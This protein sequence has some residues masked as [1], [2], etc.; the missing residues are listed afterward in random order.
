MEK[1]YLQKVIQHSTECYVGK[2]DPRKLIKIA[3]VVEAGETQDAQRPLKLSKVKDIAKFVEDN[4]GILPTS[5][6]IASKGDKIKVKKCD[7]LS[8]IYYFELPT[9]DNEIADFKECIE[10]MDGQHRLYSFDYDKQIC[11]LNKTEPYELPFT[12]YINPSLDD[13]KRVFISCNEKQD[14]VDSNLLIF[15]KY[16]LGMIKK[17]EME[18]HELVEKLSKDDPLKGHII[19]SAEKI[20]NG[21]KS[22]EII[23]A[24]EKSGINKLEIKGNCLSVDDKF[25]MIRT[26]LLAWEHLVGFDFSTSTKKNAGTA[27][28]SAGLKY[29]IMLLP[30]VFEKSLSQQ[31]R[32]D[33]DFVKK[34]LR[35]FMS[36]IGVLPEEFFTCEKHKYKFRDRS[37][38]GEFAQESITKIKTLDTG[39]FNPLA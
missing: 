33:E 10:I 17:D 35:Q 39:D 31:Q 22:K 9:E 13:R 24:I 21:V 29:M 3:K 20:K 2:V 14:K 36:S 5:I 6:T 12:L 11:L 32:F 18:N 26:Y 25:K 38:T 37:V 27:V 16:Q 23:D 28:T 8:S 1:V 15:M 4:S 30:S 34:I 7:E 19:M